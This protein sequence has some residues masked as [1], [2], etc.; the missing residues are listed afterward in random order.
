MTLALVSTHSARY[1][2]S[3][4]SGQRPGARV[5]THGAQRATPGARLPVVLSREE[6][7]S[8]LKQLRGSVADCA[9]RR[10]RERVR[11]R[12]ALVVGEIDAR[13]TNALCYK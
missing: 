7:A 8:F 9:V 11:D 13:R 3:T 6:V 10:N 4:R 5:A 1:D 2:L 12:P